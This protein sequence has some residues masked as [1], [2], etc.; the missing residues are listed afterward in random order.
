MLVQPPL[1]PLIRNSIQT[2]LLSRSIHKSSWN[3]RR[4]NTSPLRGRRCLIT[5]GTSEIGLAISKSFLDGGASAI[6]LVS[7]NKERLS[8][9]IE[10]LKSGITGIE[11]SQIIP[12]IADVSKAIPDIA[13][14]YLDPLK[15]ERVVSRNLGLTC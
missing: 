6:A 5:G 11:D 3:V 8:D 12:I 13:K 7:R 15:P 14:V 9:R 10:K 1:V 2:L 4:L